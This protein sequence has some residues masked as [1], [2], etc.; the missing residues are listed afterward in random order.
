[1]FL[2]VV[3][4]AVHI[5]RAAQGHS[6]RTDVV[7]AFMKT[8][9]VYLPLGLFDFYANY[10][11]T[12]AFGFTSSLSAFLLNSSSTPFTVI[13]SVLLFKAK[14]KPLHYFAILVSVAG[15]GIVCWQDVTATSRLG[16]DVA[17]GSNV[18]VGN[19]LGLRL[20]SPRV[21]RGSLLGRPPLA[22]AAAPR[23]RAL[24]VTTAPAVTLPYAAAAGAGKPTASPYLD[25]SAPPVFASPRPAHAAL[26]S[27]SNTAPP[28]A[29]YA[30]P[31]PSH[32]PLLGSARSVSASR[33]RASSPT[34]PLAHGPVTPSPALAHAALR[35]HDEEEVDDT[36]RKR[37]RTPAPPED[38]EGGGVPPPRTR[39]ASGS[40]IN[41]GGG[42][43]AGVWVAPASAP[44][45]LAAEFPADDRRSQGQGQQ[46]WLPPSSPRVPRGSLL[47]RPPLA[48]AAAPRARAL[49]VTTAPAVTLPYAAAAGAGKPT[50]SPYLDHSAP[51]VFASPRP[52]HAALLSHSNTAPP[53]ANY[54]SPRPSHA[55]L[56][57]SA[58]SVSASRKRASSPTL[59][60]AHGPVTQSPALAHAALRV[61]DEEEVDDTP[62]KRTRT[63]APP[64]DE[65][66]GGVPPPRTRSA[67][68]S[69]INGGGGVHA[70]VW[71]APAS[72]PAVP[73]LPPQHH[74]ESMDADPKPDPDAHS[75]SSSS[76][77]DP[78][79][80]DRNGA[81]TAMFPCETCGRSF[82]RKHD[83][84]RHH[85]VI[86]EQARPF[87][88]PNRIMC[89]FQTNRRDQ[90]L[91][92]LKNRIHCLEYVLLHEHVLAP[93]MEETFGARWREL[94]MPKLPAGVH[95]SPVVPHAAR[96][97]VASPAMSAAPDDRDNTARR[98]RS[99]SYGTGDAGPLPSIRALHLAGP[100][101]VGRGV[102]P[103]P[104]PMPGT[105]PGMGM[106]RGPVGGSAS[107]SPSGDDASS[108]SSSA[109]A[110]ASGSGGSGG[111][112]A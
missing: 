63:P 65:E 71:V 102:P 21:P 85:M 55:P 25:H 8:W 1:M 2:L 38:E 109:S 84:R 66:G 47:G 49:S 13:I 103:P 34:L 48:V 11:V 14:Y 62:R 46:T 54:A 78:S 92:H 4:I 86:H 104:M 17:D 58:R 89:Q 45:L 10:C 105:M 44:A 101:P 43:H 80:S 95:T 97:A 107:R 36:P 93:G 60:L 73:A 18:V 72:A 9:K 111:G 77:D 79:S 12:K 19:I 100:G 28:R 87:R 29:N 106:A 40:S 23:A 74:H 37:T 64:E 5:V 20:G 53:R 108:L 26:L 7:D 42:V 90:L 67:S 31:R 99:P 94:V 51:P 61:H 76:N 56:L 70:G 39:S 59:P 3:F 83:L 33:K 6:L 41:G 112:G 15:M 16:G 30:S 22:V 88:C 91:R 69:S 50:A 32:A 81:P 96:G 110:S 68:G 27:H 35:V 57:G 52:A 98:Q 82:T 24:S 75:G